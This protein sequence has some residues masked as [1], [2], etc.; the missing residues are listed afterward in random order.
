MDTNIFISDDLVARLCIINYFC[1]T[2]K[3]SFFAFNYSFR[4]AAL[5]TGREDIDFREITF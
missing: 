5:L 2:K 1:L 4:Y 3:K